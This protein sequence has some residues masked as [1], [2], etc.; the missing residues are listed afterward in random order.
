MLFAVRD[1]NWRTSGVATYIQWLNVWQT[2]YQL[3][4]SRMTRQARNKCSTVHDC[5]SGLPSMTASL[6]R[7]N[8]I[9]ISASLPGTGLET[10]LHGSDQW[11]AVP[12]RLIY[13]LNWPMLKSM[14][15]SSSSM[16]DNAVRQV[17]TGGTLKWNRAQDPWWKEEKKTFTEA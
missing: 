16:T 9:M 15:E 2:G 14:H 13:G 12:C 6:S 4:W 3:M 11:N 17:L 7:V 10:Q 1:G 5:Y 8:R